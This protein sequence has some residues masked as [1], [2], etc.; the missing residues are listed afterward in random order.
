[1]KLKDDKICW[2]GHIPGHV[3][4]YDEPLHTFCRFGYCV[5]LRCPNCKLEWGGWGP[6]ACPHK[7]GENGNLRKL[8][9]P[10]MDEKVHVA[11]KRSI[12]MRKQNQPRK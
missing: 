1:L 2:R 10:D 4:D 11:I 5:I 8:K 9:Y 3:A 12:K 7:K 6:I